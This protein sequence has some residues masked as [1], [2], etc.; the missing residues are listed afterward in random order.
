MV[1]LAAFPAK[2]DR[3]RRQLHTRTRSNLLIKTL[4]ALYTVHPTHVSMIY[5]NIQEEQKRQKKH[6]ARDHIQHTLVQSPAPSLMT[7]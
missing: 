3:P 6:V 1:T 5:Y 2:N 4:V 7:T